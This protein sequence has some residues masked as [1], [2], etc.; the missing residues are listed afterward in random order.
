MRFSTEPPSLNPNRGRVV[1][2]SRVADLVAAL[3]AFGVLGGAGF[4]FSRAW[5]EVP[6]MAWLVLGPMAV[7]GMPILLLV[8]TALGGAFLA[9]LRPTNW[10]AYVV[11]DGVFLNLRSY[12][13]ALPPGY[14]EDEPIPT[15]LFLDLKDVASVGRVV[16]VRTETGNRGTRIARAPFL[17]LHLHNDDPAGPTEAIEAACRAEAERPGVPRRTFGITSTTKH[18]HET[19]RVPEPGVVRVVGSRALHRALLEHFSEVPERTVDVDLGES[20]SRL[21]LVRDRDRAPS[22]A[23]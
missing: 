17:D 19:V 6:S 14:R 23:A 20:R 18:H 9:S 11:S 5:G 21:R 3:V 1:R 12:R 7:V 10:L 8:A 2:F 13:N 16:E 22:Q 15:V 4:G